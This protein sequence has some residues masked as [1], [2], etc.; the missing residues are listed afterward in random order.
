[1]KIVWTCQNATVRQVHDRLLS[2]RAIAYT[3]VLTTMRILE[4]KGHLISHSSL[5]RLART[6]APTV[7]QQEVLTDMVHAFV[8]RVF[9]GDSELLMRYLRHESRESLPHRSVRE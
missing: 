4:K 1:M 2:Q 8:D 9:D 7:P 3:T 6:Y 5:G